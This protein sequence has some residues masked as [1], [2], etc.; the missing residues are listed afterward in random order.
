MMMFVVLMMNRKT[1]HV[2]NNMA[3]MSYNG[4]WVALASFTSEIRLYHVNLDKKTGEYQSLKPGMV[5]SGHSRGVQCVSFAKGN[6][7]VLASVSGDG[8]LKIWRINVRWEMVIRN[9]EGRNQ[10]GEERTRH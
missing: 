9:R 6:D 5:L 10:S 7:D 2:S 1:N 8:V 3:A 4:E